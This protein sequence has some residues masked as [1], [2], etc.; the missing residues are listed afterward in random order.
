MKLGTASREYQGVKSCDRS[1]RE[2]T[3]VT[4]GDTPPGVPGYANVSENGRTGVKLSATYSVIY[5]HV[6]P[7]YEVL[8]GCK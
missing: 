5:S 2:G 7:S 4:A 1:P 3:A 8:N 6:L